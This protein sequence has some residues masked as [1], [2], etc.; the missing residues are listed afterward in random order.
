ML[1]VVPETFDKV[2]EMLLKTDKDGKLTFGRFGGTT[3]TACS[4]DDLQADFITFWTY[5]MEGGVNFGLRISASEKTTRIEIKPSGSNRDKYLP[6][7]VRHELKAHGLA[8]EEE[9]KEC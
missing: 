2:A 5:L 1:F 9:E 4:V 3:K 7:M 8:F 6:S